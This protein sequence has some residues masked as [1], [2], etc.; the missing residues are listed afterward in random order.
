MQTIKSLINQIKWDKHLNP[1]EYTIIFI[2]LG[3]EKTIAYTDIKRLDGNF[4]ILHKDN[5]EVEI[6]LHRI[7]KVKRKDKLIWKR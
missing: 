7:R 6:P 1:E 5:K 3:K 2:D 4:M